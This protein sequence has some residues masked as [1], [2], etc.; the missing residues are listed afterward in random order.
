MYL[1]VFTCKLDLSI[2]NFVNQF[3]ETSDAEFK[4]V[5]YQNVFSHNT[6]KLRV[7]TALFGVG[8]PQEI[9]DLSLKY[10]K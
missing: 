7:G 2:F 9:L 5:S 6:P 3:S 4:S 1:E 10:N 8:T